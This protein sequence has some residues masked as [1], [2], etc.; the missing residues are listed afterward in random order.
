MQ[1]SPG[2]R[3]DF[4][5][6]S[7]GRIFARVKLSVSEAGHSAPFRAERGAAHMPGGVQMSKITFGIEDLI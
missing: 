4:Y 2:V 3:P 7:T 6:M 5:S 1:E